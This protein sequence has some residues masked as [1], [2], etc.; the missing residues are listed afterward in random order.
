[1]ISIPE[2]IDI[3]PI[4]IEVTEDPAYCLAIEE[5]EAESLPNEII[6]DNAINLKNKQM[7]EMCEQFK[8]THRNSSP[9]RPKMNGAVEAANNNLKR[10]IKKMAVT[11][12]DWH[13]M[14]PYALHAY[15]TSIRTSTGATPYSLVYGMEAVLPIEGGRRSVP[16]LRVLMEAELEEAEWVRARYD[17]LNLIEEKRLNTICH[18]QCYPRRIARA[19]DKKVR[20]RSF[21]IG[22]LVL[23][24][25]LGRPTGKI[26]AKL[27]RSLFFGKK[28]IFWRRAYS[29]LY[30]W[31]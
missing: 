12:K 13:D 22:D 9:Y 25:I 19:Y 1:M 21:K 31:I 17:Q 28:G 2:G 30:G 4:E 27:R 23:K 24:K 5:G 6:T 26:Q 16:S 11:Y 18:G 10:I 14:L 8:I 3:R 29:Y 15:R 20:P 7:R